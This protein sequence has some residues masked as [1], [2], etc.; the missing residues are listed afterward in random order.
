MYTRGYHAVGVQEI[1][2]QAGVNKGSF[3]HFFPS[4]QALVLDVIETYA[5]DLQ[6]V[7][8]EA[9]TASGPMLDRMQQVFE[10]TYEAHR[11]LVD[12]YGQMLGCPIGNFAMELSGHDEC[13]RQKLW[14][15]FN[16][17]TDVIEHMLREAAPEAQWS[18]VETAT[19]AQTLIAYF[20]GVLLLAKTRN[21]PR[22]VKQLAQGAAH[23]VEA[24]RNG[25]F[26]S[27]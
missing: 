13:V 11:I 26:K 5:D 14:E 21:D 23:L 15:T 6:Q 7:W 10:A 20:E 4:K 22:M 19:T 8:R 24:A 12:R 25:G 16:G 1:C 27:S 9:M 17:W 18:A 2:A 3:Y